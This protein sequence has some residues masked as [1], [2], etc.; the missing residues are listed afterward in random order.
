M[1]RSERNNLTIKGMSS[2]QADLNLS[3]RQVHLLSKDLRQ[4]A[5]SRTLI[6]P[7]WKE[8]LYNINHKLD[9]H[10][11]LRLL[12]YTDNQNEHFNRWTVMCSDLSDFVDYLIRERNLDTSSMILK[13][14]VDGSGGF[15]KVTLLAFDFSD[16]NSK[17]MN[18]GARKCFLIGIVP[19]VSE[20]YINVKR[21]W[22]NI[23]IDRLQH[24]YN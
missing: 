1:W 4:E 2:I 10:F 15:L 17:F 7:G 19:C 24:E 6:E 13:I 23:G 9:D 3:V 5:S 20:N 14:G 16:S 11:E 12:Q 8:K 21:L 22:V 18:S